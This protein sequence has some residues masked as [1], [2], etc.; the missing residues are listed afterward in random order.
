MTGRD[1]F[2][3]ALTRHRLVAILRGV[4]WDALLPLANTL[5]DAGVRLMEVALS[6]PNDVGQIAELRANMPADV[7]VGAGTVTDAR[8]AVAAREG[9]ASFLVTP[10]VQPD[11]IAFANEH[12]L[13]LLCGALTPTEIHHAR[14][15]GARFIKLFPASVMGPEYVRALL[16][17]F[18]DLEVVVVGGVGS[19]NLGGFLEAGALGAGV[20]GALTPGV[21]DREGLETARTEAL[22]LV[23]QTSSGHIDHRSP[24]RR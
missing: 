1:A 21:G 13:G 8:L 11:V 10:G 19:K 23:G 22:E 2:A 20:G 6:N 12:A 3:A 9:G 7:L 24:D 5:V 14:S 17:P 15:L 18:P 4:P 16:G